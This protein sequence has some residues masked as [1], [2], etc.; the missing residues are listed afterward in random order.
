[1][2]VW[3]CI[4]TRRSI[5][6]FKDKEIP[7]VKLYRIL[8]SGSF[9]PC[10]GN[11]QNWRFL[12]VESHSMIEKLPK[13]C[14]DQ[15]WIS[16]APV[17]IVVCS[18]AEGLERD[19][20]EDG[21]AYA[22]QN[23]SVAME[24]MILAAWNEGIGSCW[25]GAFDVELLKRELVIP[26]DVEIHGLLA[27]GFPDEHPRQPVK[28]SA[29]ETSFFEKWDKVTRGGG[30]PLSERMPAVQEKLARKTRNVKSAVKKVAGTI[31]NKLN[32]DALK[33]KL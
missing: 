28:S 33:P 20:G 21:R 18:L 3:E 25:I 7:R 5:R 30:Y 22:L 6:R 27:I 23:T 4:K 10:A 14:G 17:V 13:I 24:N 32:L 9:A 26:D 31:V 1:M 2:E 8:E 29:A 16:T 11:S 19:F 12:I 15:D